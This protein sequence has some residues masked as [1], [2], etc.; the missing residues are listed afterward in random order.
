MC[1]GV[2]SG[3][4]RTCVVG[5]AGGGRLA[6]P[7]H[8]WWDVRVCGRLAPP[9]HSWW[10]VRVAGGSRLP[11]IAVRV[12][13]G[14][15]LPYIGGGTCVGAGGVRLP[16]IVVRGCERRSPPLQYDWLFLSVGLIQIPGYNST[17]IPIFV[18]ATYGNAA[19]Q[20]QPLIAGLRQ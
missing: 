7:L 10:D 4:D 5:R 17:S 16:Y 12:A 19:A 2:G 14:S 9:L 20:H 8:S 6:H 3:A 11:Y 15:R 18:V 13:G 1:V